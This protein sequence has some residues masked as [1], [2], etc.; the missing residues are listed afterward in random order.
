[1]V[2]GHGPHAC[3]GRFFAIYE[4]KALVVELLRNYDL[5]LAGDVDGKGADMPPT[6]R[7]KLNNIPDPRAMVEIR[8]RVF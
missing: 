2:F 7:V 1:M 8:K 4:V 6:M 5:R 3:P